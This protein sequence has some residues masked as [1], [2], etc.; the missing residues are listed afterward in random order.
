M[1]AALRATVTERGLGE[2]VRFTGRV[3]HGDVRQ[4]YDLIDFLVFPRRR[5]R[6]TEL[7]TPMKPLE[8]MAEGRIVIASDVGGHRELIVDGATG[9]LFTA[10]DP[11]ALTRRVL[12]AVAAVDG[13]DAMREAGRRFIAAERV[14]SVSAANY[15]PVYEELTAPRSADQPARDR[16]NALRLAPE[17]EG[18]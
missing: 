14:W 7:V 13:H 2:A 8:A 3:S 5:M 16:D 17:V 15:V 10:D 6:L 1:D 9:F 18:V 11:A 4:Y 12:D